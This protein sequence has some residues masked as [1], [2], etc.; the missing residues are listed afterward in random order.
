MNSDEIYNKLILNWKTSLP[1]YCQKDGISCDNIAANGGYDLK[2]KYHLG[3]ILGIE[4]SNLRDEIK[5]VLITYHKSIDTSEQ[6][7]GGSRRRRLSKRRSNKKK[8]IRR[9]RR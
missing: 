9:R 8:S 6:L 5:K 2:N 1:E 4:K 3:M 7:R